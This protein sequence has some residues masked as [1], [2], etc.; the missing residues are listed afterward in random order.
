MLTVDEKQL[1]YAAMDDAIS[2]E[3]VV[4]AEPPPGDVVVEITHAASVDAIKP[5]MSLARRMGRT[6]F[7]DKMADLGPRPTV[8]GPVALY[9]VYVPPV[10]GIDHIEALCED[11]LAAL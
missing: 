8:E 1:V 3:L 11:D 5:A 6:F 10:L 2:F 4:A 7:A 9:I